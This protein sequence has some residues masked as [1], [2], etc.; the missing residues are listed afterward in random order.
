VIRPRLTH[1]AAVLVAA[2]VLT[3]CRVDSDVSLTVK[4]NGTGNVTVVVTADAVIV[5][6]AP[7]LKTDIRVDDLTAAGW[8]VSDPVDTQDGG[9]SITLQHPFSGPIEATAILNEINGTRGPLKQ[10]VVARTGKDTN[11]TWTLAGKLEVNGGL[12]A[13]SDDGTLDLLG[14]APYIGEFNASGLDIG[15]V[16]GVT[17]NATL[18]GVVD[19]T[20]GIQ[21][22]GV[23]TWRVPMDGTPTDIATATTNVDV[24]SSISRVGRVLL[25]GLL[26][27]WAIG[28]A[29]LLLL[30]INARNRRPRTPRI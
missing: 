27:L 13:F 5:A 24:A 16:V 17:F 20:T 2:V 3:S 1:I 9:V 30:V 8:K 19:S 23:I 10:L 11:S 12:E 7:N 4:P 22:D 18:P 15:K 25:L 26:V 6:K 14:G 28:T 29:V 21:K